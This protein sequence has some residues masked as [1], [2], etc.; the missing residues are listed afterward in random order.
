MWPA[1]LIPDED[2]LFYR[3]HKSFIVNGELVPGAFQERGEGD[4]RGMSG[5]VA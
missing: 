3:I 4:A 5:R 2:L 1:E